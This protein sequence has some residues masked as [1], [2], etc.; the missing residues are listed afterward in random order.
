MNIPL[1]SL[2]RKKL[3]S[4]FRSL[5]PKT[6]HSSSEQNFINPKEISKIV[7]VR[8]NY[9]IGNIIFLT[10]IINELHRIIP[11]A[12]IDIIVGMKLAGNILKPIP[13]VD[14][15]IDIP[16]KLL[17]HPLD[18][19]SFIN[20][21]RKKRYDLAINIS[22]GSVSSEL[23]TAFLNAK[24]KA[25]F[26]N[27]KTFIQLTHSVKKEDL[28]TH[29]GSRP[30]E[31]L[32]LFSSNIP[33]DNLELDIKLSNQELIQGQNELDSLLQKFHTPQNNLAIA[34]FR[35]ARFDKKISDEWWNDWHKELLKLNSAITVI[36]I[37]SP[38]IMNKLNE[39]CLEY[40]NKDLRLLGAFFHAC[41]LYVSA[42]T[43]PLHLSCASKAKTLAFFNKTDINTYGTLGSSNKTID[44][45][46]ITPKDAAFYTYTLLK[47]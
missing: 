14:E 26:Q 17:L 9:R 11:N 20:I 36:D 25:S 13:N 38:D 23:V 16:R 10:P 2:L 24:Y 35:N 46:G 42:D 6:V 12:K 41:D 44:I 22:A 21:R 1:H 28:F 30:L 8:P 32:K 37:L 15:V 43:G 34:L 47:A 18:M 39:Q 40:S 27:D 7:I 29:S 45:N 5:L 33:T 31:L 19:I 3:R 4:W